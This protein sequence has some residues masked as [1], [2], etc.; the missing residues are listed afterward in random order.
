[1]FPVFPFRRAPP[2]KSSPRDAFNFNHQIMEK[3]NETLISHLPCEAANL[4]QTAAV[5]PGKAISVT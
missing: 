2:R 1:M 4:Q 3:I 5:M